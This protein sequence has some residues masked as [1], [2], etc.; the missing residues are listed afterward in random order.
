MSGSNNPDNNTSRQISSKGKGRA[1]TSG[2]EEG[3][4]TEEAEDYSSVYDESTLAI[5]EG[6]FVDD[7]QLQSLYI[8][9]LQ[10]PSSSAGIG[11][12]QDSLLQQQPE[13]GQD[14]TAEI[15]R[16]MLSSKE[17]ELIDPA[18]ITTA[19]SS[20]IPNQAG[21]IPTYSSYQEPSGIPWSQSPSTYQSGAGRIDLSTS[22]APWLAI[23]GQ[24]NSF[25]S[26]Y[27]EV[28]TS[29][30]YFR[31][32][33]TPSVPTFPLV[34]SVSPPMQGTSLQSLYTG[35]PLATSSQPVRTP[36]L[37]AF[38]SIQHT[39]ETSLPSNRDSLARRQS[40]KSS[41]SDS[42]V[43]ACDTCRRRKVKVRLYPR[44]E[45]LMMVM[46]IIL[47]FPTSAIDNNQYVASALDSDYHAL[48]PILYRR[49]VHLQEQRE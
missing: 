38:S 32:Y 48:Q 42:H 22:N 44:L 3:E 4:T 8:P 10:Q 20:Y 24:E 9:T 15:L 23:S 25:P 21:G 41:E 28:G 26:A 18:T 46:L 31:S 47:L 30:S 19:E 45:V 12:W 37:P 14:E 34:S 27:G 43:P 6:I 40:A 16:I 33:S 1:T 17:E 39:S 49:E 7:E 5:P 2:L 35:N 11:G 36:S 29:P 13:A